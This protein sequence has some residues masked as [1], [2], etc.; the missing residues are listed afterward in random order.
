MKRNLIATFALAVAAM[1]VSAP[2]VLAESQSQATIPFNFQMGRSAL[3]AGT[4]V[5]STNGF[6]PIAVRDTKSGHTLMALGMHEEN[7]RSSRSRLVFH[8]YGSKYFLAEIWGT[9]TSGVKVPETK[10][11]Q[12]YRAANSIPVQEQVILLA[13]K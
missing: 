11:E 4:Y 13:M 6:G 5:V 2:A 10:R 1:A 8:V 3:P 7:P 12:E 9:G